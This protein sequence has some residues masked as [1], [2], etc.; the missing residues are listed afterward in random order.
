MV[1]RRTFVGAAFDNDSSFGRVNRV[2]IVQ[3]RYGS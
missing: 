3:R 2:L 1:G